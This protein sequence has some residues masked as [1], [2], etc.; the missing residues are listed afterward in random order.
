VTLS[1]IESATFRTVAQCLRN[2]GHRMRSVNVTSLFVYLAITLFMGAENGSD[3]IM[4]NGG[5]VI[6]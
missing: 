6:E 3:Y 4:S 2:L 1:T 5:T